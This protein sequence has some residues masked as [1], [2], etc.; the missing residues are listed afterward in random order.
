MSDTDAWRE[1]LRRI[2][3][4]TQRLRA[5]PAEQRA[6]EA[7]IEIVGQLIELNQAVSNLSEAVYAVADAPQQQQ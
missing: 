6:S 2:Q 1:M 4:T 7:L 3:D 5:I